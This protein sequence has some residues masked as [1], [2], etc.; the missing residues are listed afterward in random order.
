[1]NSELSIILVDDEP[2]HSA[3][4][5]RNLIKAGVSNPIVTLE[6]GQKLLNFIFAREEHENQ[7]IP[8]KILILLDINMPGL[9]G[10]EVLKTLKSNPLTQHIPV[11][12]L[13]TSDDPT[14]I[15]SCFQLGCN[16]YLVKPVE[17]HQFVEKIQEVAHF[18][19]LT[20]IPSVVI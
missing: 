4:V 11:I 17:H 10:T 5:R 14:E 9:H 8:E 16:A 20:Q 13:T 15:N 1:M 2:A 6:S 7:P 3:L 19:T 12:M 18:I